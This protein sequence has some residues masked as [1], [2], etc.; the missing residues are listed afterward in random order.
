MKNLEKILSSHHHHLQYNWSIS[1]CGKNEVTQC[2]LN[3]TYTE[4]Y[5]LKNIYKCTEA[6]CRNYFMWEYHQRLDIRSLITEPIKLYYWRFILDLNLQ[7]Q[8]CASGVPKIISLCLKTT[9]NCRAWFAITANININSNVILESSCIN[10]LTIFTQHSV[11][12]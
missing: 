7:N 4:T 12:L 6:K 9:W 5:R 8:N 10:K 3:N 11:V 1:C 2:K